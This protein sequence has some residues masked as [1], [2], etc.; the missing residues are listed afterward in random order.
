MSSVFSDKD[1]VRQRFVSAPYSR[2]SVNG[3]AG[4]TAGP[5]QTRAA[6]MTL[7]ATKDDKKRAS[8]G[9]EPR[10]QGAVFSTA[11]SYSPT[12]RTLNVPAMIAGRGLGVAAVGFGA[13]SRRATE[14]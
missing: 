11:P 7:Q 6:D 8:A 9:T 14:R 10:L 1:C 13:R 4:K 2:G 12:T 3:G 5:T